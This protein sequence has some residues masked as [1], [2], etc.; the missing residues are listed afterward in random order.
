[1]TK[2]RVLDSYARE[3]ARGDR[4][5]L[6]ITGQHSENEERID[7]LGHTLGERLQDKGKSAWKP[8]VKRDD[9]ERMIQRLTDG[10]TDGVVIYDMERLLRR[11][12]DAFRI[13]QLAER[14]FKI[15]DS[16]MEYDL[17]TAA[18]QKAFYDAAVSAQ[19]YSHRLSTKISR[20]NRQKA[21]RGE[22]KRGR[23]RAFGFEDDSTTVRES[24]RRHIRHVDHMIRE[25]RRTWQEAC[26]YLDGQGL[27][28]TA[29][30]HTPGC[31]EHAESLTPHQLKQY[32]C[33]CPGGKWRPDTLQIA[34]KNPR[35]AGHTKVGKTLIGRLPGEPILDPVDWQELVQMIASRRGR[36]PVDVTLCAG[37]EAPTRCWNCG[38][39]LAVQIHTKGKT[40]A[41]APDLLASLTQSGSYLSAPVPDEVRRVYMCNRR[42][43]GYEGNCG[44]V[45]GDRYA[46]DYIVATLVIE[47][48]SSPESVEML[49]QIRG[50]QR[51]LRKPHE[52]ELTR[53]R[54]VRDYWDKAVNNG[55]LEPERHQVLMADVN[56]KLRAAEKKLTQIGTTDLVVPQAEARSTVLSRWLAAGPPGQRKM[57]RQAFA[58]RPLYIEPGSSLDTP[59]ALLKR[60]HWQR[61]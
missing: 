17:T 28:T 56:Q 46:L 49:A 8:G 39:S 3:S 38:G 50:R 14:G 7:D 57:F 36:P 4:R 47:E 29:I 21:L 42:R 43:L 48:L 52:Q 44:K 61:K 1:M 40:Y 26:D 51:M 16:D 12:D 24:E 59:E 23:Y 30:V 11:V 13:V 31:A 10:L 37:L 15:F 20:A 6:P 19:Y 33:E 53:L 9:W 45:I 34:L 55:D 54:G 2:R 18:G 5:N 41:D 35:M 22:G 58:E 60:L 27:T 32:T 25:Q